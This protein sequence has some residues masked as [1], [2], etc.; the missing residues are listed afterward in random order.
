MDALAHWMQRWAACA[1][2][3]QEVDVGAFKPRHVLTSLLVRDGGQ[4]GVLQ[5]EDCRR[6]GTVQKTRSQHNAYH[7]ASLKFHLQLKDEQLALTHPSLKDKDSSEARSC[8]PLQLRLAMDILHEAPTGAQGCEYAK[9]CLSHRR[10]DWDV[11]SVGVLWLAC[12]PL[13]CCRCAPEFVP[14]ANSTR[15]SFY[16]II[17]AYADVLN[18]RVLRQL[19]QRPVHALALAEET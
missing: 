3:R 18:E 14:M 8:T 19:K 9:R 15:H 5:L 6:H 11:C 2:C 17:D 13:L 16:H 4:R 1:T 10:Q 12:W 7:E